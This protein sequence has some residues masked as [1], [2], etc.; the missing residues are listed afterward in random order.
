MVLPTGVWITLAL[1]VFTALVLRR[2]VFG[3]RVF[4]LGSNELAARACGIATDRLKLVIYGSA[5]E[6]L[7][8]ARGIQLSPLRPGDPAGAIGPAPDVIGAGG[9]G[10]GGA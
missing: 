4:A 5:G 3:R 2:T 1:A 8:V 10:R 7:G 6:E 9:V